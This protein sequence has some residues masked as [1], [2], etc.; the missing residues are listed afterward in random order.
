MHSSGT[1]IFVNSEEYSNLTAR[2]TKLLKPQL[3]AIESVFAELKPQTQDFLQSVFKTARDDK[4][5]EIVN[6]P[7]RLVIGGGGSK[8]QC[9]RDASVEAFTVKGS[10]RPPEVVQLTV[11]DDFDFP[12]PSSDFNRF[13]VAYGLSFPIDQ[14]PKMIHPK[15]VDQKATP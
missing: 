4:D 10:K 14:L 13:S 8:L 12:L 11:P 6:Q 1:E 15:D 2:E 5:R 3:K 7:I 9:F